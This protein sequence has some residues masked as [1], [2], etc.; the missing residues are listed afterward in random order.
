MRVEAVGEGLVVQGAFEAVLVADHP[1]DGALSHTARDGIFYPLTDDA[2]DLRGN[3][4]PGMFPE[5]VS[6][7]D[8]SRFGTG[9]Q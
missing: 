9:P 6:L 1:V 8:S 7:R 5:L 4:V 2:F 3:R